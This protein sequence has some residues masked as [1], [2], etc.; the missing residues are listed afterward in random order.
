MEKYQCRI[1]SDVPVWT[2]TVLAQSRVRDVVII[3]RRGPAQAKFT[4]KELRELGELAN[5]DVI[6][7]PT[8]LQVD[9]AAEAVL[10][11]NPA[12]RRNLDILRDWSQRTPE[13]RPRRLHRGPQL[14]CRKPERDR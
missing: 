14:R 8:E 11:E 6:V 3:G 12:A 10:K 4:T 9:E 2:L 5:A 7:C 13:G 1:S